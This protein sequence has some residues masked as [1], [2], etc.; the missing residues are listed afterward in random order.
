VLSDAEARAR[1]LKILDDSRT[2]ADLDQ[3]ITAEH[4]AKTHA[5]FGDAVR[6]LAERDASGLDGALRERFAQVL[7]R[8]VES[9]E[10][11]KLAGILERGA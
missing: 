1:L 6:F 10:A 2:F 7:S 11:L 5:L 4:A 3:A 8:M 9:T